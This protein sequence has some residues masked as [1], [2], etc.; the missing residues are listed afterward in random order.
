MRG[1]ELRIAETRA[2]N[3]ALRK[4]YSVGICSAEELVTPQTASRRS[5]MRSQLNALVSRYHLDVEAVKNY[6]SAFLGVESLEKAT[7]N[8]IANFVSHLDK[9]LTSD[10]AATRCLLNGYQRTTR[11]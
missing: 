11:T 7:E 10:S 1:A 5:I 4:A 2:V 3:R 6:G 9:H 8:Q